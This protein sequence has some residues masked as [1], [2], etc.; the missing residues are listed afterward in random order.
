[1][2]QRWFDQTFSLPGYWWFYVILVVVCLVLFIILILWFIGSDREKD[3]YMCPNC[4]EHFKV[5]WYVIT[6]ALHVDNVY[7]LKCPGCGKKDWC[8][9]LWWK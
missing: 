2:I 5:K 8:N 9:S 1:M 4:G 7:L 3:T 6:T